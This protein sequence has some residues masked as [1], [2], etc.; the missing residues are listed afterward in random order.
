MDLKQKEKCIK[1]VW[2]VLSQNDYYLYNTDMLYY[3]KGIMNNETFRDYRITLFRRWV[4]DCIRR[5]INKNPNICR[6][7]LPDLYP[8][9]PVEHIVESFGD[10]LRTAI[11]N[12]G[13]PDN[14]YEL[15]RSDEEL[16]NGGIKKFVDGNIIRIPDNIIRD[17]YYLKYKGEEMIIRLEQPFS[18][19]FLYFPRYFS[20]KTYVHINDF[21]MDSLLRLMED[22]LGSIVEKFKFKMEYMFL[23]WEHFIDLPFNTQMET[24]INSK[25]HLRVLIENCESY[26]RIK[27]E[28]TEENEF[29]NLHT[30]SSEGLSL[31]ER[32][33]R[34]YDTIFNIDKN[35]RKIGEKPLPVWPGFTRMQNR[36]APHIK[37][38]PQ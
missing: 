9:N 8:A 4:A 13:I 34:F 14:S 27:K 5:K 19:I 31:S 28:S 1:E 11:N 3:S 16:L 18:K 35:L 26:V 37:K 29:L 12:S 32:C 36:F 2:N 23:F 20:Y 17:G 30:Q 6:S 10:E 22:G 38:L 21:N 25:M 33:D 15:Y 24:F 7:S